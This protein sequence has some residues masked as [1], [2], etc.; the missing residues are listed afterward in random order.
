MRRKH[1]KWVELVPTIKSLLNVT[2]HQSTGLTS[3][4]L[5]FGKSVQDEILKLV[6]FP[7]N[8]KL[9]HEYLITMAREN[10]KRNFKYCKKQ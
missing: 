7:E 1:T 8:E 5:H 6:Q 2:I 3:Y 10:L 9:S 4:K